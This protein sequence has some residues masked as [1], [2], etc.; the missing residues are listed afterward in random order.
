MDDIIKSDSPLYGRTQIEV[1][2]EW[3]VMSNPQF[4]VIRH[5]DADSGFESDNVSGAQIIVDTILNTEELAHV[6][7]IKNG[8]VYYID[9]FL[10]GGGGLNIVGAAFLG[11]LWHPEEFEDIDPMEILQEYLSFY[12]S[13]FDVSTQGVFMYPAVVDPH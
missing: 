2:P 9:N 10:V 3:V 1:E 5:Q 8:N 4:I 7:A 6:D 13:N 11:K 12:D